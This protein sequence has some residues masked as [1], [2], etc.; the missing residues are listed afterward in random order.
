MAVPSKDTIKA[1]QGNLIEYAKHYYEFASGM[2]KN[3][4]SYKTYYA[5]RD[6]VMQMAANLRMIEQMYPG[7]TEF[8]PKNYTAIYHPISKGRDNIL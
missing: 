5:L 2:R 8:K 4:G 1:Y 3:N 6:K 7:I